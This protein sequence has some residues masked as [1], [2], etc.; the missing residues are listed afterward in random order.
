MFIIN[1]FYLPSS[2]VKLSGYFRYATISDGNSFNDLQ[3]RLGKKFYKDIFIGYEFGYAHYKFVNV[4][5]YSPQNYDTH[6]LWMEW[7]AKKSKKVRLNLG[8][9]FGYAPSINYILREGYGEIFYTPVPFFTLNGRIGASSSFRSDASYNTIYVT[10]SAY[11]S[12]F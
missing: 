6:S 11:W 10:L 9:K 1:G 7:N 8:G 2:I 5:Y 3:L 12:F 4:L